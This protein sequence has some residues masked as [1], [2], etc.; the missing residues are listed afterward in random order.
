MSLKP[1]LA[2]EKKNICMYVL[3]IEQVSQLSALVQ[4]QLEYHSRAS[5]ILQQL[6]RKMEDRYRSI[7]LPGIEINL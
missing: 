5:E 2:E 1:G 7:L 4:A 6:S 3:Q